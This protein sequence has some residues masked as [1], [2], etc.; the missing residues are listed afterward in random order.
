MA[1][2]T[3]YT[4][5]TP[6]WVDVST[7]DP[8]ATK[9][10]YTGL[11]GWE[12]DPTPMPDAGGYEMFLLRGKLVSA[13]GPTQ[14]GAPPAWSVYIASDDVDATAAAITEHGGM[15][16]VEP[17]DVFDAGRMAFGADPTGAM[18]G[19]WQAKLHIGAQL[20]NEPSTFVW[21]ELVTPNPVASQAF[22]TA[23]FGWDPEAMGDS[24]WGQDV[25]NGPMAGLMANPDETSPH[26][27]TYF[28]VASIDDAVA[29]V[30]QLGGTVLSG[31]TET[32]FGPI[33]AV[34]DTQ[35]AAFSVIQLAT[36]DAS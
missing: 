17:M 8:E 18:F 28:G 36:P 30:A 23:V 22:Y 10:F 31:P 33:A 3:S 11:F 32:P 24:Y 6:N 5:G 16:F 14:G 7:N 20:A 25:G 19:V 35:G 15:L 34:V 2:F 26:W 1:E 21:N 9:A 13:L 29:N 12:P 27:V 4:H